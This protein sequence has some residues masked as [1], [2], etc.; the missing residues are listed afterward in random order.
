[1]YPARTIR[2]AYNDCCNNNFYRIRSLRSDWI[3]NS[4]SQVRGSL[5]NKAQQPLDRQVR[6]DRH[7]STT[8]KATTHVG[9]M[10]S[11]WAVSSNHSY[12]GIVFCGHYRRIVPLSFLNSSLR[13]PFLLRE[14]IPPYRD[15]FDAGMAAPV[16]RIVSFQLA[17]SAPIELKIR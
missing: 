8:G 4:R 9:S 2:K 12:H 1:M 17:I 5:G 11:D 15:Q 16:L 3:C 14:F 13:R 10:W 7:L 6:A